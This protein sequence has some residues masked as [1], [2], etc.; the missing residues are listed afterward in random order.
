MS[1]ALN[2]ITGV[3]KVEK[4]GSQTYTVYYDP[5]MDIRK[6]VFRALAKADCPILEMSSS[7]MSLEEIFLKLTQR[8]EKK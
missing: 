5:D 4:T 1:D 7:G 8:S 2:S 3:K 6:A